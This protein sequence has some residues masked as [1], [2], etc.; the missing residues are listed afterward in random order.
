MEGPVGLWADRSFSL[1]WEVFFVL[2]IFS[3]K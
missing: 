1:E 2:E 3:L